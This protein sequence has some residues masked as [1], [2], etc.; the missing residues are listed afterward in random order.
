MTDLWDP[1][2]LATVGWI[3]NRY[4]EILEIGDRVRIGQ[5]G[6]PCTTYRSSDEVP[7]A[8][9]ETIERDAD[10]IIRFRAILESSGAA[11]DL[12]NQ[13]VASDRIW[14]IHPSE[15]EKIRA[16]ILDERS[17]GHSDDTKHSVAPMETMRD[18]NS[19]IEGRIKDMEY[20]GTEIEQTIAGSIRELAGDM[21]RLHRGEVPV[22]SRD[23]ADKYDRTLQTEVSSSDLQDRNDHDLETRD[24]YKGPDP[25]TLRDRHDFSDSEEDYESKHGEPQ[26]RSR[27]D[28]SDSEEHYG[29]QDGAHQ[30]RSRNSDTNR[31]PRGHRDAHDHFPGPSGDGYCDA[32]VAIDAPDAP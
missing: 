22:F 19:S 11:I 20:R 5:E 16:R 26:R 7:S 12:N 17:Y 4:A 2:R 23:F 27:H 13:N 10:G 6:D 30:R 9:V 28:F 25:D 21:M 18:T 3:M 32:V 1:E 8:R 14:E 15:V 31:S 24:V 29:S